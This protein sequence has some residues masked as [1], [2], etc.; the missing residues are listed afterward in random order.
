MNGVFLFLVTTPEASPFLSFNHTSIH[1]ISTLRL[2]HSSSHF[3]S[4][5]P[6]LPSTPNPLHL[7]PILTLNRTPS[8]SI[9]SYSLI[10]TSWLHFMNNY[11][12][13]EN[14][15]TIQIYHLHTS[16]KSCFHSIFLPIQL[17]ITLSVSHS[18][19]INNMLRRLNI[20][21][22]SETNRNTEHSFNYIELGVI[23]VSTVHEE[24]T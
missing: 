5:T 1:L 12:M 24:T 21:Y 7:C 23:V 3:H 17:L 22:Q 6:S 4:V 19:I 13:L 15:K 14:I 10:Y 11:S 9:S 20:E 2:T 8:L 16:L 18:F